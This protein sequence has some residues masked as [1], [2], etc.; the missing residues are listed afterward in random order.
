[1]LMMMIKNE[2][3]EKKNCEV[4]KKGR[5]N[6]ESDIEMDDGFLMVIDLR[7]A[8]RKKLNLKKKIKLN[9]NVNIV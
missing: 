7:H 5:K 1:M 8:E 6:Y 4:N 2:G 9:E 3:E